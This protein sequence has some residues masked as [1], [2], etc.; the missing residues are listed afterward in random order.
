MY[1]KI[2]IL[3]TFPD[4]RQLGQPLIA[5]TMVSKLQNFDLSVLQIEYEHNMESF[6]K[7]T[8]LYMSSNYVF[9]SI[10]RDRV[11]ISP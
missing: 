10:A 9:L 3:Y 11:L 7:T 8:F 4:L 5:M 6:T 2:F 1:I